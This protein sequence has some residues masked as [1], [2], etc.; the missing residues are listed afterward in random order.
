MKRLFFNIFFS[1]I[2]FTYVFSTVGVCVIG[3]YCGGEL[4]K[5]SLFSKPNS[6]CEGEDE[7][8]ENDDCCQNDVRHVVNQQDFPFPQL[9]TDCKAPII[10]LSFFDFQFSVIN[11]SENNKELLISSNEIEPPNLVQQDIVSHSV[12]RI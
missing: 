11:N 10:Q 8:E 3:H 4:E 1:F 12:I 7:D 6:C 5:V 9:V 2:V